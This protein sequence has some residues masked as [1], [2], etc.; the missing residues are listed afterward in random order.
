MGFTD[1][2][3]RTLIRP[4]HDWKALIGVLISG[5]GIAWAIAKW[6]AT[7]PTRDE[8]NSTRDDIVRIRIELPT[9]NAKIERVEQSQQRVERAVDQVIGKLDERKGRGR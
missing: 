3:I 2:E 8:L 4:K 7:T 5:A 1:D 9:M 6:A